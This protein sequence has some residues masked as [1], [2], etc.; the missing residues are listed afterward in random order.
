MGVPTLCGMLFTARGLGVLLG[1]DTAMAPRTRR[2]SVVIDTALLTAALL[3]LVMLRLNP[4]VVPWLQM[5]LGLL[6]A[7]IGF[8]TLALRRA[9]T[10]GGKAAAYVAALL[11]F[12]MMVAVARTHDPAGF[13]TVFRG[14]GS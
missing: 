4:L 12:S 14:A 1:I 2:V 5:K 10:R 7:Y 11:C 3:L 6:A 9:R 13:L 8:G